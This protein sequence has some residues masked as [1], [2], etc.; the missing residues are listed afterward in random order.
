LNR[1]VFHYRAQNNQD[2][3][4]KRG[5]TLAKIAHIFGVESKDL[6][7]KNELASLTIYPNQMIV[8][9]R[10]LENGTVYFEQYAIQYNDTI[11]SISRSFSISQVEL[12]KYNDFSKLRLKENQVLRI[13]IN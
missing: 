8:I 2:Y 11:D 9:P 5:D 10:K 13:P 3:I 1:D 4:I 7:G 12:M 6:M